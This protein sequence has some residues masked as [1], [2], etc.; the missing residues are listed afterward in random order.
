MKQKYLKTIVGLTIA[1]LA[2]ILFTT[3]KN[4]Y[5]D[6]TSVVPSTAEI[7][8]KEHVNKLKEIASLSKDTQIEANNYLQGLNKKELL[9]AIAEVAT[10]T[11][12]YSQMSLFSG[13]ARQTL[14]GKLS[15][16][17]L[18]SL[19]ENPDL[20]DIF[21]TYMISI[22]QA[23]N[24]ANKSKNSN[25]VNRVLREI[26]MDEKNSEELRFTSLAQVDTYTEGDLPE[27]KKLMDSSNSSERTKGFAY[28]TINKLD[29]AEGSVLAEKILK[30]ADRY[31]STLVIA[32]MNTLGDFSAN[33]NKINQNE[34]EIDL[35][36]YAL[37]TT[38][39]QDIVRGAV[40]SLGR[41]KNETSVAAVINYRSKINDEDLVR[42]YLDMNYLVV[43]KML[44]SNDRAQ[45]ETALTCVEIA[46]FLNFTPALNGL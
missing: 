13:A 39:N 21:K 4:G 43:E 6:A 5:G 7:A 16:S 25:Q 46:P 42:Y 41:F 11:Q 10:E 22:K 9:T 12:D 14:I 3:V 37:N 23:E 29:P 27:L 36:T 31:S 45:I 19:L 20:N 8:K 44:K 33:L 40:F 34:D 28:K 2:W 1:V 26:S 35:I 32:V 24:Y 17:E 38:K 18:I 15:D 30:N